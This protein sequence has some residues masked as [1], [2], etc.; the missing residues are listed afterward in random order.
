MRAGL[1]SVAILSFGLAGCSVLTPEREPRLHKLRSSGTPEEFAILPSKPLE[2]PADLTALP[3]PTP[4]GVNRTDLTPRADVAAALGGSLARN[5]SPEGAVP[6]RDSALVAAAGR[7]G[8]DA[9][10]RDTLAA[11]DL[12]FRKR[13]TRFNATFLPIDKYFD[14]YS[15]Q[16]INAYDWLETYVGSGAWT[17]A[18]PPAE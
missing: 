16:A 18:A 2:T 7:F 14:A 4:G 3:E 10:I 11:E 13:K 17:P 8:V 6:G 12:A 9:T 15:E 5:G 1:L